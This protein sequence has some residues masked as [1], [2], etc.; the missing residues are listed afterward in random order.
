MCGES[1]E[2]SW[3]LARTHVLKEYSVKDEDVKSVAK[4]AKLVSVRLWTLM[5]ALCFAT[6]TLLPPHAQAADRQWDGDFY[7]C[8]TRAQVWQ[9]T[10]SIGPSPTA[11]Q[12]QDIANT[13]CWTGNDVPDADDHAILDSST[14]VLDRA[15]YVG[16]DDQF[17]RLSV[18]ATDYGLYGNG[19]T[20]TV[21]DT[22][23][24][25]NG[26][27]NV[28]GA[29]LAS[30]KTTIANGTMNL[31]T[32]SNAVANLFVGTSTVGSGTY[33]LSGGA[34]VTAI[35]TVGFSGA[36]TVNQTGGTNST[37][38]LRFAEG[39]NSSG[40]YNLRGGTLNVS[41][42][43]GEGLGTG[44]LNVDGGTYNGPGVTSVE[45]FNVGMANNGNFTLTD[46]RQIY[47]RIEIVGGAANGTLIQK[48]GVNAI[49]DGLYVGAFGEG[50]YNLQ[51]GTLASAYQEIGSGGTGHFTQTGGINTASTQISLGNI[52]TGTYT[53]AGGTLNV[54]S[55]A[56]GSGTGTLAI[57][58][59]TLNHT[60]ATINVD[61]F[62]WSDNASFQLTNGKSLNTQNQY[63][64][65]GTFTQTSGD[66]SSN[67]FN[68][69]YDLGDA[70]Y[71]LNGGSLTTNNMV[72]AD[73]N[74]TGTFNLNGGSLAANNVSVGV[75]GLAGVN[76]GTGIFNH[77]AT[78]FRPDGDVYLGRDKSSSG[79]YNLN[80]GTL[81][82][83]RKYIGFEGDGIFNHNG[84]SN[85]STTG[86]IILASELG[87]TGTY[88]LNAGTLRT[89]QVVDGDGISTFNFNG[90]NIE[91]LGTKFE[92]ETLNLG[93]QAGSSAF[94]DIGIGHNYVTHNQT[95]GASGTGSMRL[96]GGTNTVGGTMT[97]GLHNGSTGSYSLNEGTNTVSTM[98]I[99]GEFGGSGN[100]YLN[101]G[102]L[103]VGNLQ[104]G[105]GS[106]TLAINGGSLNLTGSM[107]A[108]DHLQ[109]GLTRRGDLVIGDG[110]TLIADTV[111][112]GFSGTLTQETG[113]ISHIGQLNLGSFGRGLVELKG[114]VLNVNQI[115]N[116][117]G[118][119]AS[120]LRINGGL[121]NMVGSGSSIDVD[122][123]EVGRGVGNSGSFTLSG[124]EFVQ[125]FVTLIG[126]GGAGTVTQSGGLFESLASFRIGSGQYILNDGELRVSNVTNIAGT[127]S[128]L[129]DG[130]NL[131]VSG[132]AVNVDKFKVGA[133]T[134]HAGGFELKEGQTLTTDLLAV[135]ERG[136]GLFIQA[137]GT[138][139]VD[140]VSVGTHGGAS[141]IIALSDGALNAT[142]IEVGGQTG[143]IG[144]LDVGGVVNAGSLTTRNLGSVVS[145][146]SGGVIV[147]DSLTVE[148]GA[149]VQSYWGA[150]D[151]DGAI[152]AADMITA[153]K[154]GVG[155]NGINSRWDTST[156]IVARTGNGQLEIAEGGTV[157][158][159][160][161]FIGQYDGSNGTIEV[162][163][164][165]ARL[166]IGS[167]G[168]FVGGG[169][170]SGGIGTIVVTNGGTVSAESLT[171]R[172][173]SKLELNGGS[174]IA[175][176]IVNNG[177]ITGRGT[178][179]ASVI[180]NQE[181][182]ALT[183][184]TTLTASLIN[185]ADASIWVSDNSTAIFAGD[186]VH[187]GATI[188]VASGSTAIYHGTV[189]ASGSF[190][191]SGLNLF[192]G[193]LLAGS[194]GEEEL[195]T[196][197]GDFS[198]AD[199]ALTVLDISGKARGD[200]YD[201]LNVT[202]VANL[203]GVLQLNWLEFANTLID[204]TTTFDLL[205]AGSFVG[206]FDQIQLLGFEFDLN[207][208]L[209]FVANNASSE[210]LRLSFS[211]PS[212]VPAPDSLWLLISGCCIF[213]L[214]SYRLCKENTCKPRGWATV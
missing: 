69:A 134:G 101:G 164:N 23:N 157:S 151:T 135:G 79:T 191:G 195:L 179:Q 132:I 94:L 76:G 200:E 199:S 70:T 9:L 89:I 54:A 53:L 111:G 124:D 174:V 156:L 165:D 57:R 39:T 118:I 213:S 176:T 188:D 73:F 36:G 130:G 141:G 208:H 162:G 138:S 155:G 71:N 90:G 126:L 33:N 82:G 55:F 105:A 136:S 72:I 108:M 119:P 30:D 34:L 60:G 173:G 81:S 159:N 187:M 152:F 98:I 178:I 143:G 211:Q 14:T 103:N 184:D 3:P 78:V 163:G 175:G 204:V 113:S 180:D 86:G 45:F 194:V 107:M 121:V 65:A 150:V 144:I 77:N 177:L 190:D 43:V 35:Q 24:V 193:T 64:N 5:G 110:Q 74:K 131:E 12:A 51:G 182:I 140:T 22:V 8:L 170:S 148:S 153:G 196:F 91:L 21:G 46:G 67:N 48:S 189:V 84:G 49:A 61:N 142:N 50:N 44:S 25:Q 123:F 32:G 66:N 210:S 20:L 59:G 85:I 198:L 117:P 206:E 4:S 112:V 166:E 133:Q 80:A 149:R 203:N 11:G 40:T 2:M 97:V 127:G 201:A 158:A 185:N 115:T 18:F 47:S 207:W 186:L 161:A 29:R 62:E 171:V 197:A 63:I 145:T 96:N 154:A 17:G 181:L 102:T 104:N 41:S 167:Q 95:I 169:I 125:S 214:R 38:L 160:R 75:N 212:S 137:G 205:T 122:F 92:V 168:L 183:G 6:V 93:H 83:A 28:E 13:S 7:S 37:T 68:L 31:I 106:G 202:G 56:N 100:Y 10:G 116:N 146:Q 16:S 27:L 52:G 109:V 15:L 147:T 114:G 19:S 87:S 88:N 172:E 209:D 192:T 1:L 120:T 139:T 42:S 129:V 99:G 128:L 58:G 26:S